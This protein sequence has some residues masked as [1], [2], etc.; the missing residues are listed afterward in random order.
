MTRLLQDFKGIGD[1]GVQIFLR[2]VQA[3]WPEVRPYADDRARAGAGALGLP[4]AA[5]DLA[6][7]VE[8]DEFTRF[9]CGLVRVDFAGDAD[10]LRAA[11]A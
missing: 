1:V 6:E 4:T 7:L 5:T 8:E 2:E 9:V 11:A 3:L 10:E